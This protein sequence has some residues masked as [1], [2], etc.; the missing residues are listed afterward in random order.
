MYNNNR[1]FSSKLK[2]CSPLQH[3][4]I[5]TG[6]KPQSVKILVLNI[7]ANARKTNIKNK[8]RENPKNF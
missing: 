4:C 8:M 2:G 3:S 5:L 7:S 6:T 1:W